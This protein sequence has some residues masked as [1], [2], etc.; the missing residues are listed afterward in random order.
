[1][2]PTLIKLIAESRKGENASKQSKTFDAFDFEDD[3]K[4]ESIVDDDSGRIAEILIK[5]ISVVF[6]SMYRAHID[7]FLG[8]LDGNDQLLGKKNI[9]HI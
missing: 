3:V 9:Y 2:L 1:M 7:E 4:K 5:N 6:P 8:M